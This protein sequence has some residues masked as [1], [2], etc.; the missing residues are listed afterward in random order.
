APYAL[1][2]IASRTDCASSTLN[3][4]SS[5][6]MSSR[7]RCPTRNPFPS[8]TIQPIG[9][10][11]NNRRSNGAKSVATNERRSIGQNYNTGDW[12]WSPSPRLP[13]SARAESLEVEGYR[14]GARVGWPE[15][16]VVNEDCGRLEVV[17]LWCRG[18][19]GDGDIIGKRCHHG[20]V[21]AAAS[22]QHIKCADRLG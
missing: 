1:P 12:R 15:V 18:R 4:S 5:T 10:T 8:M 11:G 2:S 22:D 9:F 6:S 20:L 7:S 13:P 19:G 21:C 16:S 3:S 14:I 17:R